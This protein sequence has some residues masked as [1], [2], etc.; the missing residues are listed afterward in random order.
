MS[1]QAGFARALLDPAMSAPAE[2]S[3]WNGSDPARRFAVYRNNV[4]VSLIDALADTFPVT[5]ALVG[6]EFFRAMARVFIQVH[7]VKTRV[8]ARVGEAFPDFVATFAPAAC[9][10]YL[11]DV[12]RLEMLRVC[13]YHAADVPTLEVH[14]MA[15]A[16]TD[17]QALPTLRVQL[18]PG[19]FLLQSQYA[20]YSLWLA[21]QGELSI[22]A[23]NPEQAQSV[24]IFRRG[25][26]AEVIRLSAAQGHF[27]DQLLAGT[28]LAVAA[29]HA[30]Q[31]DPRFDLSTFVA[32]L[33][34]LQL[35]TG[36]HHADKHHD[37]SCQ[38]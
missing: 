24:L 35:I 20:V 34:R 5:Q 11:A 25:L 6:E 15:Q 22:T 3:S 31:H 10:A 26:D 28:G 7:P 9:L 27:V 17:P 32:T 36:L 38:P 8:L 18:H 37:H 21:H 19:V 33:I 16:L 4:M 23:V 12:A 2:L 13:A 29:T 1:D 14:A 30:V